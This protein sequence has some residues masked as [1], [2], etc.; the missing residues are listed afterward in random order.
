M[1]KKK[2][3]FVINLEFEVWGDELNN[4]VT[5]CPQL[6]LHT[7][8]TSIQG[9]L[10]KLSEAVKLFFDQAEAHYNLA[11]VVEELERQD[12]SVPP[13]AWRPADRRSG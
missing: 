2:R 8:D 3:K 13:W 11:Q 9:A 5:S 10:E 1:E 4:V 12:L 7:E 6:N